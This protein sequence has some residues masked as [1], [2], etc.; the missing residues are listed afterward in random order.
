MTDGV[1]PGKII[2]EKKQIASFIAKQMTDI[3]WSN[4]G[5]I[6]NDTHANVI[7][8]YDRIEGACLREKALKAKV[9]LMKNKVIESL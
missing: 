6:L 1:R 4:L 8:M 7:W 9:T 2:S 3:S 5:R